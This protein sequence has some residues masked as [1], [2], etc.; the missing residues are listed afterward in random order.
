MNRD[1]LTPEQR[2]D[3]TGNLVTRWVRRDKKQSAATSSIPAPGAFGKRT[4]EEKVEQ[5]R[6]AEE[7]VA[8]YRV[9][10]DETKEQ[11]AERKAKNKLNAG[12]LRAEA[13]L[14]FKHRND[15]SI[16]DYEVNDLFKHLTESATVDPKSIDE[17]LL[18][19]YSD[20]K[21]ALLKTDLAKRRAA[22]EDD[23]VEASRPNRHKLGAHY[24]NHPEDR[25]YLQGIIENGITDHEE[26]Q[27]TLRVVHDNPDQFDAVLSFLEERSTPDGLGDYL[28]HKVKA[29]RDG[30][31]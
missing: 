12:Y 13:V 18:R 28:D 14:R 5:K 31:L 11:K 7:F 22:G 21:K 26:V 8:Q 24:A 10:K 3:K 1:N 17:T 2:P 4:E 20:F 25:P 9:P 30:T 29:L 15:D 27:E 23:V 19:G 16:D 6:K